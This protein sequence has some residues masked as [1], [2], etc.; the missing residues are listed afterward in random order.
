MLAAAEFFVYFYTCNA[1]KAQLDG[2][3]GQEHVRS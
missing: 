3:I 1:Q 2:S